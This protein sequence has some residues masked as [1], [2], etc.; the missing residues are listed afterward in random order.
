MSCHNHVVCQCHASSLHAWARASSCHPLHSVTVL[1]RLLRPG[2]GPHGAMVDPIRS[3]VRARRSRFAPN[4]AFS[5]KSHAA[6]D[7][8]QPRPFLSSL[9]SAS[10][11]R[12]ETKTDKAKKALGVVCLPSSCPSPAAF[13]ASPRPFSPLSPFTLLP[14]CFAWL[15]EGANAQARGRGGRRRQGWPFQLGSC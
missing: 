8:H 14:T 5:Q 7:H 12:T 6:C 9:L 10:S 1:L 11:F 3:P 4:P 15:E 13:L 2:P